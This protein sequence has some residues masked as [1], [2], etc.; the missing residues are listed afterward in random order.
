MYQVQSRV[1]I[2][3]FYS[4]LFLLFVSSCYI[5]ADLELLSLETKWTMN[6][7][8]IVGIHNNNL[9]LKG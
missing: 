6:L 9:H 5:V 8:Q 4:V 3:I 7:D 1:E 2:N